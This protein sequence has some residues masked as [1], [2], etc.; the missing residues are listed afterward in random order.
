M[1]LNELSL[2]LRMLAAKQLRENPL[3]ITCFWPWENKIRCSILWGLVYP[4]KM[5]KYF[6]LK[7]DQRKGC[8]VKC[9]CG[10]VLSVLILRCFFYLIIFFS[11]K[12][13][14]DVCMCLLILLKFLILGEFDLILKQ[15]D[16]SREGLFSRF[17]SQ[18]L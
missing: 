5:T 12:V 18:Y 15:G 9:P 6:L 4:V 16:S 8:L 1:R 14:V 13:C 17:L 11:P 2:P 7:A 10:V 3:D